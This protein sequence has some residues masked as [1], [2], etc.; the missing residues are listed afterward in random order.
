MLQCSALLQVG[1]RAAAAVQHARSSSAPQPRETGVRLQTN[2]RKAVVSMNWNGAG[3]GPVMRLGKK[4]LRQEQRCGWTLEW[5]NS[6]KEC[7]KH[8]R[9]VA[10][11]EE[12][13]LP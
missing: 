4:G 5:C 1:A 3:G 13:L 6:P 10:Q 7:A 8:D 2:G 12:F 11:L 9:K